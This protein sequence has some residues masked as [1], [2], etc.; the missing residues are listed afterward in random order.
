MWVLYQY[1][2]LLKANPNSLLFLYKQANFVT[3]FLASSTRA[4]CAANKVVKCPLKTRTHHW[5]DTKSKKF[6]AWD[7]TRFNQPLTNVSTQNVN[8]GRNPFRGTLVKYATSTMT[9]PKR[10]FITVLSAM[11]VDQARDLELII[12]IACVAML[13]F[14]W[15]TNITA[16]LNH[17]KETVRSVTNQ[18]FK[19]PSL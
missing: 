9:L 19:A 4:V 1:S 11:C 13:A 5:I 7:A 16:S 14:L 15:V 8:Q 6:Y 2:C 10:P 3:Q 17:C 12:D 18:C